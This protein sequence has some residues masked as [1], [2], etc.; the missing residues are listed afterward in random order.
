MGT[1]KCK[2]A[3]AAEKKRKSQKKKLGPKG[4]AVVRETKKGY[5]VYYGTR[6]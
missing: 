4:W 3:A 5:S 6:K 2:T 1:I